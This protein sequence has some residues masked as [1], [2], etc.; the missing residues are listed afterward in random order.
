MNTL[1]ITSGA[2]E[3]LNSDLFPVLGAMKINAGSKRGILL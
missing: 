2:S 3:P 1:N